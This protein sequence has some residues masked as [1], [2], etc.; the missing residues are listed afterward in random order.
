MRT[1][2]FR[3]DYAVFSDNLDSHEVITVFSLGKQ[4]PTKRASAECSVNG[5]VQ[6][7]VRRLVSRLKNLQTII[8]TAKSVCEMIEVIDIARRSTQATYY[9]R[10]ATSFA[11]LVFFRKVL[12]P[13]SLKY[14]SKKLCQEKRGHLQ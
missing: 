5:I 4:D 13:M 11:S 7:S 8:K 12:I 3:L 2:L 6:E 1:H 10:S 9:C 14:A